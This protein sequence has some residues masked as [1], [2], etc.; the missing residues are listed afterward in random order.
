M[1]GRSRDHGM[2]KLAKRT[3]ELSHKNRAVGSGSS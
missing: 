1:R 2:G 3:M